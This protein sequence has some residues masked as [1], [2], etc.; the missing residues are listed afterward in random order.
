MDSIV[1]KDILLATS[2][3]A[4]CFAVALCSSVTMKKVPLVRV[5]KIALIF[6]VIHTAL[7]F[8]GW[9]FGDFIARYVIHFVKYIGMLLLVLVGGQ[10]I[11]DVFS[12]EKSQSLS[13]LRN[14]VLAAFADSI[15]ALAVG[16][17]LSMSGRS[18]S[19]MESILISIFLITILT[20]VVGIKGGCF[21][22][23]RAGRPAS[24][25][26]GIVLIALGINI[27]LDIF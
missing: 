21:I 13:S 3:C 5:L 25:M 14:I 20:V 12:Q 18:L 11:K 23:K 7:L 26:G 16:I 1:L 27:V 6:A 24:L 17:S 4:D 8:I 22:G 2:L 19:G 10:M 9:A 15:D